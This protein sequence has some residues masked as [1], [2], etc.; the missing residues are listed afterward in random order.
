MA[1]KVVWGYRCVRFSGQ[2]VDTA[3]KIVLGP[4]K[5]PESLLQRTYPSWKQRYFQPGKDGQK[6]GYATDQPTQWVLF[7][8]LSLRFAYFLRHIE[9]WWEL[10]CFG[11]VVA[12]VFQTPAVMD[13]P[14][15]RAVMHVQQRTDNM[16]G[17]TYTQKFPQRTPCALN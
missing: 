4:P 9:P 12:A 1:C 7:N 13:G 11:L 3:F 10:V 8:I 16:C 5:C 15:R 17:P 14:W 6:W 2:N